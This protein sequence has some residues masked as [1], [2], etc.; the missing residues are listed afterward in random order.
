MPYKSLAQMRGA[1]S[2]ALGPSMKARA[3]EWADATSNISQLPEHVEKKT[4]Q[5][6]IKKRLS[7]RGK[8]TGKGGPEV[9]DINRNITKGNDVNPKENLP[10]HPV[11]IGLPTLR[12]VAVPIPGPKPLP[13]PSEQKKLNPPVQFKGKPKLPYSDKTATPGPKSFNNIVVPSQRI[14]LA[15]NQGSILPPAKKVSFPKFRDIIYPA[16]PKK[17]ILK[18]HII[19][20]G[21]QTK[22]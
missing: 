4:K 12:P 13:K 16:D 1:F 15:A 22:Q 9:R 6:I 8:Y 19:N 14:P 18:R 5:G 3:Q 21:Q 11:P 7:L 17:R 10:E 2:G 20:A